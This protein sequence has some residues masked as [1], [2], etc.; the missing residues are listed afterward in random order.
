MHVIWRVHPCSSTDR[1]LC[2]RD[3]EILR[4]GTSIVAA[5]VA[6]HLCTASR[7]A[8]T[9][10]I[11]NV[12]R[13][14]R[15][16]GQSAGEGKKPADAK[17]RKKGRS[18]K[19][20]KG[21]Q[22]KH[23]KPAVDVSPKRPLSA[24]NLFFA[25]YR[26][27]IDEEQ[28]ASAKRKGNS[29]LAR[30]V[31]NHWKTMDESA[32]APYRKKAQED[33]G[34]YKKELQARQGLQGFH[35]PKRLES[36]LSQAIEFSNSKNSNSSPVGGSPVIAPRLL[37]VEENPPVPTSVSVDHSS[38]GNDDPSS[39]KKSSAS[40]EVS[41]ISHDW[42]SVAEEQSEN[43]NNNNETTKTGP[44]TAGKLADFIRQATAVGPTTQD[45]KKRGFSQD[46]EEQQV[47]V[48]SKKKR[49]L[50]EL[51]M[52]DK[53][54]SSAIAE[55]FRKKGS[56]T[57]TPEFKKQQ[58]HQTTFSE[59]AEQKFPDNENNDDDDGDDEDTVTEKTS[60]EEEEED[61]E[62]PTL[63][64]HL[65]DD[66]VLTNES[67]KAPQQKKRTGPS[68]IV[69]QATQYQEG[70]EQADCLQ[71]EE[72]EEDENSKHNKPQEENQE[73][74]SYKNRAQQF[75][76]A[77]V[78]QDFAADHL[79]PLD[80]HY[81]GLSEL[82]PDHENE[83]NAALASV[84]SKQDSQS[85]FCA[86]GKDYSTP[87]Q[88]NCQEKQD[89]QPGLGPFHKNCA[90]QASATA[91]GHMSPTKEYDPKRKENYGTS[92]HEAPFQSLVEKYYQEQKGD[93]Q[94]TSS[95]KKT[96]NSS[97][98]LLEQVLEEASQQVRSDSS[99]KS[100]SSLPQ[101]VLPSQPQQSLYS[102][103]RILFSAPQRLL[104]NP[105][106]VDGQ[107]DD[108]PEPTSSFPPPPKVAKRSPVINLQATN[109]L[110]DGNS[111]CSS[112]GK[113]PVAAG[114]SLK[115]LMSNFDDNDFK[116]LSQTFQKR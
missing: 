29:A 71:R 47:A 32:K 17:E 78:L 68:S 4:L 36:I 107:F 101:Q 65:E 50:P 76:D 90:T 79:V 106:C 34:R 66:A 99:Q 28:A 39:K 33:L 22:K 57:V 61:E 52:L 58:Q 18:V 14:S 112:D 60:L 19:K 92:S 23:S 15:S 5:D 48:A 62:D 54:K 24:Y 110:L 35:T 82:L 114:Q 84:D 55:L 77:D 11:V 88:G 105:A 111:S 104:R 20:A 102:P 1:S 80:L 59:A 7:I 10:S 2:L 9:N 81:G 69:G 109:P 75:H 37:N 103:Q 53:R 94:D 64:E 42:V 8:M 30:T 93:N 51:P 13:G 27:H 31:A 113:Q 73:A 16:S 96:G 98:E 115:S 3:R 70:G 95:P 85:G 43:N 89:S 49:K 116:F 97:Q 74:G 40:S 46:N 72:G 91:V 41:D 63:F 26:K 21:R 56:T 67:S 108:A 87:G 86:F 100:Q 45:G 25:E 44:A 38:A 83:F 12:L 6:L